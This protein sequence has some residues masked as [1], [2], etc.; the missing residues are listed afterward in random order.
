M[1]T[2]I[3]SKVFRSGDIFLMDSKIMSQLVL[4][5]TDLTST[6]SA[7]DQRSALA[8]HEVQRVGQNPNGLCLNESQS[9][10]WPNTSIGITTKM[11]IEFQ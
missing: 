5:I 6:R 1:K 10:R 7:L 4:I 2:A 3:V 8:S 9:L 11:L